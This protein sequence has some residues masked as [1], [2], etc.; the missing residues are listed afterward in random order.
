MSFRDLDQFYDDT[1]KLPI[2]GKVYVVP[3]VD[4]K[5][6]LALQRMLGTALAANGGADVT[7]DDFAAIELDDDGERD[8][9]QRCL[10]TA[11]DAM[12]ADAVSWPRLRHAGI[13]AFMW[14]AGNRELAEEVWNTPEGRGKAVKQP[15]DR[16]TK[17]TRSARRG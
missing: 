15:Q 8:M 9:Y 3:P 12:V 5:T 13:T 10:G 7:P 1:L 14:A 4:A 2:G 6:G 11:W 17:T 16:K